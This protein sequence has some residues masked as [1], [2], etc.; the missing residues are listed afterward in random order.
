MTSAHGEA[1][2]SG[3]PGS[4]TLGE[5]GVAS[6]SLDGKASGKL[7]LRQTVGTN[8]TTSAM[9]VD[10]EGNRL[11][12]REPTLVELANGEFCGICATN[13]G[14]VTAVYRLLPRTPKHKKN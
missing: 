11:P 2:Q 9:Y 10:G 5:A 12:L 13:R 7:H 14:R 1:R 3:L 4:K 6:Y 8:P